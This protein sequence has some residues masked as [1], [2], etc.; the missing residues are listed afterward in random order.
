MKHT[1]TL[2]KNLEI[3]QDLKDLDNIKRKKVEAI[4]GKLTDFQWTEHKKLFTLKNKN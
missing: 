4:I 3:P 1:Y 2:K